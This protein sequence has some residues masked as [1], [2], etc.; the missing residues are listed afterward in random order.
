[1][2]ALY[3]LAPP[4]GL[5]TFPYTT[6]FRS[7]AAVMPCQFAAQDGN[8]PAF[9]RRLIAQRVQRAPGAQQTLLHQILGQVRVAAQPHRIAVQVR[10]R[11]S[12]RLNSSHVKNSYTVFSL[13]K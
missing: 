7:L 9:G 11:K 1:Y 12:T 6:L 10:D 2:I 4:G 3:L 5:P 8:Q 13:K